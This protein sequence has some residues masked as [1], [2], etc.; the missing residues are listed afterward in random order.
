MPRLSQTFL[1]QPAI[2]KIAEGGGVVAYLSEWL[3]LWYHFLSA[4][5]AERYL[6]G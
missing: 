6:D 2:L 4:G 1:L 3:V 5:D